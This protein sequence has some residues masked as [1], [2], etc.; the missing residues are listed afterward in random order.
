[1]PPTD[2]RLLAIHR[3][4]DAPTPPLD[5]LVGARQYWIEHPDW[6]ELL[7]PN[8]PSHH[9]KMV[10]RALYLDQWAEFIPHGARV[11][12]LVP[13]GKLQFPWRFYSLATVGAAMGAAAALDRRVPEH[14][15]RAAVVALSLTAAAVDAVPYLGAPARYEPYEGVAHHIGRR[16]RSAELPTDRFVRVEQ[17]ALPPA[18]PAY[19]VAKSRVMFTEYMNKTLRPIYGIYR[20][21]P[22]LDESRAAGASVRFAGIRPQVLEPDPL[23]A[24][25][26]G[27]D[28]FDPEPNATWRIRPER[29]D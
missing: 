5:N 20:V 13:M 16:A 8:S 28:A 2:P 27:D 19:R 14:R 17:L 22:S 15:L 6:M 25:R 29:I 3:G 7:D 10:E 11:L 24:L 21:I 12:D 4:G 26:V 23:V 9:D 1:M 18:D